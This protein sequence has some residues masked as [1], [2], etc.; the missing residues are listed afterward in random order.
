MDLGIIR[1]VQYSDNA[2]II[3]ITPTYSGCP[4]IYFIKEEIINKEPSVIE[5]FAYRNTWNRQGNSFLQMLYERFELM[6][7]LLDNDGVLVLRIDFH[8]GVDPL[9]ARTEKDVRLFEPGAEG[10]YRFRAQELH[11]VMDSQLRAF[12]PV[13]ID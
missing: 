12:F 4:A 8:W 10:G 3:T 1:N 2:F 5:M 6:K 9:D 13:G 11:L 7:Q